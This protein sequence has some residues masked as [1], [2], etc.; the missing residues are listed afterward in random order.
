MTD[1]VRSSGRPGWSDL[2]DWFEQ[3]FP[4]AFRSSPHTVGMRA[5]EYVQDGRYVVRVEAPG[6]DPDKDVEVTVAEGVLTVRVERHEEVKEDK[7][8]EFRYGSFER[9]A[10]LPA[11]VRDDVTATY[12]DGI[13][14]VSIGLDESKPETKRIP[15]S[16]T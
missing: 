1:I 8:S 14:E 4:T 13:V 9:R 2:V 16:T 6:V 15:V 11:H 3:G 10:L 5:E 12:R 7:R